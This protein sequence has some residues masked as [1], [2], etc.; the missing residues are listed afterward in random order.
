MGHRVVVRR[1]VRDTRGKGCLSKRS[2]LMLPGSPPL[3][4]TSWCAVPT[5]PPSVQTRRR[6]GCALLQCNARSSRMLDRDGR[7]HPAASARSSNAERATRIAAHRFVTAGPLALPQV[8]I[9]IVRSVSSRDR[10]GGLGRQGVHSRYISRPNRRTAVRNDCC[11]VLP[12]AALM[13]STPDGSCRG[14]RPAV[15]RRADEQLA[16]YAAGAR[17]ATGGSVRLGWL[18]DE[19]TLRCGR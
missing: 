15:P 14:S 12:P 13:S 10:R 2:P 16:G 5:T 9:P 19:S 3:T 7:Q 17:V 1:R 18:L 11:H 8:K 6:Q 4:R